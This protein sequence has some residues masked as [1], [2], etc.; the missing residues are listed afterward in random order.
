[1]QG[2]ADALERDVD[3]LGAMVRESA[4]LREMLASPVLSRDEQGRAMAAVAEQGGLSET[5]TNT[6][7]LMASKRRLFVVPAFVRVLEDM[8]AEQKGQVTAQIRTATQLSDDQRSRL[9]EALKGETGR[10]VKLDVEV[11][12]SLVGGMVVRLGSKMIDTSVRAKLAA[13]QNTMKEVR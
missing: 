10:D 7:R 5:M 1:M 3:A 4:E 11:D 9:A 6:L 13:L 12:E 8:L 2:D